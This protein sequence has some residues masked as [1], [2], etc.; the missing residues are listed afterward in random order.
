MTARVSRRSQTCKGTTVVYCHDDNKYPSRVLLHVRF[1]IAASLTGCV[2]FLEKQMFL[3]RVYFI[4]VS[5]MIL[6][7]FVCGK[8]FHL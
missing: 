2:C 5:V 3:P 1:Y 8:S 7:G 4:A 6:R